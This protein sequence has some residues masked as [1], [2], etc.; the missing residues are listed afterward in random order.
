MKALKSVHNPVLRAEFHYQRFVIQQ[1]RVG[2]LWIVLAAALVIPALLLA[3]LFTGAGLAAPH[4]PA[5]LALLPYMDNPNL[6]T[7]ALALLLTMMIA[8]YLVVTL[9]LLG[10]SAGSISRE[11]QHGTWDALRL[12]D[13]GA[14]RIILGKWWASLRALDG[15]LLMMTVLRVG[16][17]SLYLGSLA[18]ALTVLE[19]AALGSISTL[20]MARPPTATAALPLLILLTLV[21]G[22]LDAGLTAALGLL[23]AL[24]EA[25]AGSVVGTLAVG[26]RFVGTLAAAGWMLHSLETLRRGDAAGLLALS[27]AGGAVYAVLLLATLWLARRL[28]G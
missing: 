12:T 7:L 23:A 4:V 27:L 11:K 19:A 18:P 5:A 25:A 21:Y 20:D 13:V 6:L 28:V 15:D 26:L 10:L 16:F 3:L 9:I 8:L 2:R 1:G 17:V 24:P 22:A 14:G